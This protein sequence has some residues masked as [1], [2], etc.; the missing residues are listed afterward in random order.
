MD[1]NMPN[2]ALLSFCLFLLFVFSSNAQEQNENT[3]GHGKPLYREAIQLYK[4]T[5]PVDTDLLVQQK[6]EKISAANDKI[7]YLLDRGYCRIDNYIELFYDESVYKMVY[8]SFSVPD[9][10]I[11]SEFEEDGIVYIL[12]YVY[13]EGKPRDSNPN[14]YTVVTISDNDI[15][16]RFIKINFFLKHYIEDAWQ[17]LDDN[18]I[19]IRKIFY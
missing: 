17:Y 9:G 12:K 1:K 5:L 3:L 18:S 4:Y 7:N 19:Y 16:H 11:Y 10:Y 14:F 6:P 8:L 13:E 2:R 15:L